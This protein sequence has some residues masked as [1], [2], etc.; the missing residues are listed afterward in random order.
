[1]AVVVLNENPP[2]LAH[3]QLIRNRTYGQCFV[4]YHTPQS[5]LLWMLPFFRA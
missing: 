2:R 4:S 5:L 3:W 1:V